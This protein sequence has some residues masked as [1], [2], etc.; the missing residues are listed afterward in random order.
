MAIVYILSNPSFPDWYKIGV[1]NDL[2]A[3]VKKLSQSTSIPLPFECFFAC[4]V[5]DAKNI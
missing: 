3:R 1:T 5:S 4:E 2:D